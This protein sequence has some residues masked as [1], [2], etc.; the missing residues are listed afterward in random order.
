VKRILPVVVIFGAVL[1]PAAHATTVTTATQTITFGPGLTEFV[2]ATQQ[3]QLFDSS[4]GTLESVTIGGTYGFFSSMT[5]SNSAA[6]ASRGTARTESAAAFN[7]SNT[8]INSVLESLLDTSGSATV[9]GITLDPA[10]FDILGGRA[11]CNLASGASTIAASNA[12]T[13]TSAP[14]TDNTASDLLAF[15]AAG[16]GLFD[17]LFNTA[18]ATLLSNTGGNTGA[19]ETTTAKGTVNLFYTYD[20]I[21]NP[22]PTPAP[23]PAAVALLGVGLLGAGVSR[24]S[25]RQQQQ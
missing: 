23:E 18:T 10:A 17:V 15:E 8:A 21:P 9:G 4:L 2:D 14:V 5:I 16:G 7:S 24:R 6:N 22:P 11:S 25:R 12:N 19:S 3:L 20:A 1:G 13:V